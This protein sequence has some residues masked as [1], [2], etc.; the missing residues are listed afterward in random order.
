[1]DPSNA[2]LMKPSQVNTALLCAISSGTPAMLWGP[3]GIGKSSFVDQLSRTLTIA[4]RDLRIS[5]L[6]PVDLRGL[7]HVLNGRASWAVPEFL[8]VDGKG[9]LFL[10]ELNGGTQLTQAATYQLV[11]DRRLGEY[12]LPDGWSIVAAGNRENDRGVVYRMPKGL[13]NRFIHINVA[14]DL[15]E[16]CQWAVRSGIATE[17]IAFLRFRDELLHQF[18]PQSPER[19]FPTPRSWE[20]VSR[21]LND[22]QLTQDIEYPMIAGTVGEAAATWFMGFLDV[23]RNIQSPD[24]ILMNPATA[25]VPEEPATLYAISTS[26]ARRATAVNMEQIVTYANR[27]PDEFSVLLVKD[28]IDRTP[29]TAD[30]RAFISWASEH[31]DVMS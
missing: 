30:T 2:P 28:A 29:D 25:I 7:P 21:L 16:W 19:A 18:D 22:G 31:Q 12:E 17:V 20:F 4:L 27:L 9:I 15:D 11:L 24:V 26:L 23:I 1:M 6:D 14:V 10:D 3:P 5:L 8:P 13:Q